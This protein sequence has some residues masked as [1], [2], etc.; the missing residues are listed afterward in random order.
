MPPTRVYA[1]KSLALTSEHAAVKAF[2]IVTFALL[3][4][5]GAQIEIPHQPVPFTMQTFF[6]LLSGGL[7]GMRKGSLSMVL[8][9]GL[10][11]V[12]FPVFSS[13]GFGLARILG[14]TGGYL[15]SFPIAAFVV[16]W[17]LS[18]RWS[19]GWIA[20]S[21]ALGLLAVFVLG[22][23]QLGAVTGM[24]WGDA[25]SSGF[26]IFSWWDIL[27]LVAASAVVRSVGPGIVKPT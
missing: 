22:T 25:F 20:F 12:G 27:K 8:Y 14:P 1:L 15:L 5:V 19:F 13:A 23:L 17:L 10:G 18:I 2:W 4:A 16:G 24:E 7:L 26:L 6:V 21:M 9:L 11:I 3:T